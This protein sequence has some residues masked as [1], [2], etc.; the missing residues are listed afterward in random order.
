MMRTTLLACALCLLAPAAHAQQQVTLKSG[1]T[2]V[3]DVKFDGD[4][5]LID[6]DGAST[7]IPFAEISS[8]APAQFNERRE[9]QQLLLRALESRLAGSTPKEAV[10]L[11][12]EASKLDPEN[13]H[14]AFWLAT[15][16][17][18]AGYGKIARTKF[19]AQ[20][21]AIEEAYPDRVTRLAR[22]IER[23][24]ALEALPAD[25]VERIDAFNAA[26][27]AKTVDPNN[28][29]MLRMAAAFRVLDQFNDPIDQS[30]V[31]V[32]GIGG[33]DQ[34][35]QFSDGYFFF[36]TFTGN[37][38]RQQQGQVVVSQF[39]L[40]QLQQPIRVS[41]DEAAM[42]RE[43][44]VERF[45][46]KD[47]RP[48]HISVVD[49]DKKPLEGV[50]VQVRTMQ[51]GH[52]VIDART[53]AD[54]GANFDA[55]PGEYGFVVQGEGFNPA[56]GQ[57]QIAAENAG[58]S[59]QKVV[60]H[61]AVGG[62]VRLEWRTKSW[63]PGAEA[64]TGTTTIS[65][66]PFQGGYYGGNVASSFRLGQVDDK[67]V[68]QVMQMHYGP[69]PAGAGTPIKRLAL[70]ADVSA[71]ER[72]SR[73]AE[74]FEQLDLAD[75]DQL[76][77]EFKAAEL[78]AGA[79]NVGGNQMQVHVRPGDVIVGRTSTHDPRSGQPMEVTFKA[80]V[81]S[82][83]DAN[84]AEGDASPQAEAG[85]RAVPAVLFPAAPVADPPPR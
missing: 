45:D 25:L 78:I 8:V 65:V 2:L 53:D 11:L 27:A 51:N 73:A 67:L 43:I 26:A 21:E 31:Q 69:M 56:N 35:E 64:T 63:Q 38:N 70:G 40:K 30:A 18:E 9:A 39:G 66:A 3:G 81:E 46:Q 1:P 19:E 44:V 7:R 36:S 24:V 28:P 76:G 83:E 13:P 58:G 4:A 49:R 60:L 20:R 82:S 71:D 42:G 5:V 68:L 41:A 14:I 84:A 12:A 52:V 79:P 57:L 48:V 17:V 22:S 15:N 80:I 61:R 50:S 32:Q 34:L 47:K 75:Y 59:E 54:G 74:R 23:R 6:V 62:S 33:Q 72:E 10:A 55:F 37:N 77:D 16:L 29:G 85:P